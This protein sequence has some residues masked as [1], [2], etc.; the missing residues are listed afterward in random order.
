[1]RRIGNGELCRCQCKKF[2]G[3]QKL[4]QS[5]L[6]AGVRAGLSGER[7]N[8]V[9]GNATGTGMGGRERPVVR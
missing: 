4:R 7:L 5:N 3:N 9:Q 2:S 8:T 1:M 6:T